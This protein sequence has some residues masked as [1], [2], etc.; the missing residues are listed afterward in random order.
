MQLEWNTTYNKQIISMDS[1]I[2]YHL[3]KATSQT[4]PLHYILHL[5]IKKAS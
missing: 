5:I 2:D 3:I 1:G 4:I